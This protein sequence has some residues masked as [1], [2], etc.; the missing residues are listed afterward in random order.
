[1][2]VDP[3]RSADDAAAAQ[4]QNPPAPMSEELTA[5]TSPTDGASSP[6]PLEVPVAA[7]AAS[8]PVPPTQ[9]EPVTDLGNDVAEDEDEGPVQP[10]A[11]LEYIDESVDEEDLTF[12]WYILKVA[13][14]REDSIKDALLRRVGVL[15]LVWHPA[16]FQG[17][18]YAAI[19]AALVLSMGVSV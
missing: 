18:L 4:A 8:E 9:P 16:L 3:D 7:D 15:A 2:V 10:V 1:M 12:D 14:N 19:C 5:G 17:A 6:E 11:P 13:V